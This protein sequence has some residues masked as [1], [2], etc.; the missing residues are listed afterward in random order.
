[1][2]DT[3]EFR[4]HDIQTHLGLANYLD[5]KQTGT[6]KSIS[7]R[8][9]TAEDMTP[10]QKLV[11]KTYIQY[12]DT[13]NVTQVAQ[14]NE[15][16][17][18]HYSIAYKIDYLRDF[19]AFNVSIP[20]Y[21]FGTNIIHYNRPPTHR[22]FSASKHADINVN[23]SESY[24]R[25]F[26]FFQKFFVA[27]FGSIEIYPQLVEINRIDL[28]YNQVFDSKDDAFEYLNQL[29]KLKKKYARDAS[30][31][32]RD[33]KTSIVYKT[34][35]Y[36]FKVYHKGTEFA[37]NDAPKLREI[38]ESGTGSFDVA[39]YQSFADRILRYELTLR[40]SQIGHLYMHKLFRSGCEIWQ[41]GLKLWNKAKQK[42]S[43]GASKYFD[44]RAGLEPEE[45][46]LID[47]VN[48]HIN[49]SK[50]FY[51]AGDE[52]MST[53]DNETSHPA[54]FAYPQ[55]RERFNQASLF[56]PE[57]WA[58]LCSRF[59]TLLDEFK[60]DLHEDSSG[61]LRKVEAYNLKIVADRDKLISL[62]F[63]KK[64]ALYKEI[65]PTI[66]VQKM[67]V[68]LTMLET[69]TFEEIADSNVFDRQTWWRHRKTLAAVGVTQ[70]SL[71]SLTTRADM[72]LRSYNTHVLFNSS[73]FKNLNF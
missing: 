63:D 73:T 70:T 22:A 1:M 55:K 56:T 68:L 8:A 44:F 28:C 66:S 51:L 13:G 16:K 45:R 54:F 53:F 37:K 3:V 48:H 49:K 12:H 14:F 18:S 34:D 43:A 20:K 4:I 35:R 6:G 25:L 5:R 42:K 58:L 71:L 38:N 32:S 21:I 57:L 17:S 69:Q 10:Q 31:Y 30:N 15:L 40:N 41:A 29:R 26:K 7:I 46:K 72:D 65:P 52:R 47:Y 39:Q 2:I 62:G 9:G 36:S 33:W 61:V 59:T 60:I 27:E 19:I 67:K 50:K 64:S 23:L 11:H 24:K